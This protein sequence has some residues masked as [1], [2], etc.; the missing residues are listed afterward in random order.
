MVLAIGEPLRFQ[1]ERRR[2]PGLS[3]GARR[4]LARQVV[5]QVM[6]EIA[7]LSQ[8]KI[9]AFVADRRAS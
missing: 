2:A 9:T 3:A 4:E 5:A 7:R 6:A 8:K 1:E